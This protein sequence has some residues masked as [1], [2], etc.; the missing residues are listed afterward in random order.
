MI[1]E[2]NL[3]ELKNKTSIILHFTIKHTTIHLIRF[4]RWFEERNKF[5]FKEKNGF[6]YTQQSEI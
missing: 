4:Q 6:R 2:E 5:R 1:E 3:Q